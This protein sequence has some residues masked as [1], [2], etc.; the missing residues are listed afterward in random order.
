MFV[1]WMN[2]VGLIILRLFFTVSTTHIG[3]KRYE[4]SNSALLNSRTVKYLIIILNLCMRC[5]NLIPGMTL[6][7]KNADLFT[8]GCCR[9]RNALLVKLCTSWG[10][11]ASPENRFQEYLAVTSRWVGCQECQQIFVLS[12]HFFNFGKSHFA[13]KRRSLGRYSSLADS[14]HGVC[15]FVCLTKIVTMDFLARNSR[16]LNGSYAE[17][18]S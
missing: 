11:D 3:L 13:D 15:L 4:C 16:T 18:L 17:A 7:K 6:W 2:K 1:S 10:D 9:V 8:S 12:G 5:D 14:D